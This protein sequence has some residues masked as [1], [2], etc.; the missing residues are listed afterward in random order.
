[1]TWK[2]LY[3]LKASGSIAGQILSYSNKKILALNYFPAS[4]LVMYHLGLTL[5][6]PSEGDGVQCFTKYCVRRC[7][8]I[9]TIP[10][11]RLQPAS[12]YR[13][14]QLSTQSTKTSS[15]TE[16]ALRKAPSPH[17]LCVCKTSGLWEGDARAK[18]G[19]QPGNWSSPAAWL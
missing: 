7:F 2:S 14:Q 6:P 4:W 17:G 10:K 15:N 3:L 13:N 8:I 18:E 9:M 1:M 12:G 19:I 16:Q 11:S 5:A